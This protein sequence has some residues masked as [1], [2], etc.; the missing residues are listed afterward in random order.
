MAFVS[1]DFTVILDGKTL[2]GF[3]DLTPVKIDT[4]KPEVPKRKYNLHTDYKVAGKTFAEYVTRR[5]LKDGIGFN[6]KSDW[7][8]S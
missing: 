7:K 5:M 4:P 1:D 6:P 2:S 8:D 3:S